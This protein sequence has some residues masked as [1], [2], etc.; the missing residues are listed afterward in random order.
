M[1]LE[2]LTSDV[3]DTEEATGTWAQ[4]PI[5]R[6]NDNCVSLSKTKGRNQEMARTESWVGVDY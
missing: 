4:V 6:N 1:S 2:L 5:V 3:L